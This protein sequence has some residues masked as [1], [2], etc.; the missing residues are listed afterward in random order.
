MK[1]SRLNE[2]YSMLSVH[3][4]SEKLKG[5]N[6]YHDEMKRLQA[7]LAATTKRADTC[8]QIIDQRLA[9]IAGLQKELTALKTPHCCNDCYHLSPLKCGDFIC[10]VPTNGAYYVFPHKPWLCGH[11]KAKGTK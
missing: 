3:A 11:F 1:L 2:I 4:G 7:E 8:D 5:L 6:E 9:E 10:G